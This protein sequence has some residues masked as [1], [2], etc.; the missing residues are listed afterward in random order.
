MLLLAS[1]LAKSALEL[2]NRTGQLDD[3]DDDG[4]VAGNDDDYDDS[5]EPSLA[6]T[7]VCFYC[8]RTSPL[9]ELVFRSGRDRSST[10]AA[11]ILLYISGISFEFFRSLYDFIRFVALFCS[12]HSPCSCCVSLKKERKLIALDPQREDRFGIA[13]DPMEDQFGIHQQRHAE[14]HG[15][16]HDQVV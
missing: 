12:A 13:L 2:N 3:D 1:K 7:S 9:V 16:E 6:S 14:A 15:K 4:D 5:T 10:P 11:D 8:F